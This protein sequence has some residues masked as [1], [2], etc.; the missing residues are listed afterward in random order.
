MT[1]E[2][3]YCFAGAQEAIYLLFQVLLR[4]GGHCLV[5]WPGYQSLYEVARG[6]GAE[7]SLVELHE[8][9][10]W[11]LSLERVR[12][13]WRR[14]TRLVAVNFPHNPTG[15]VLET[16]ELR[17]LAQLCEERGAWLFSDEV[18]YGA[19]WQDAPASQAVDLNCRAISLGVMSKSFGLAGLRVGWV[20]CR[21]PE[22]LRQV[23]ALKDYTSICNAA[24]SEAL[25]FIGLRA[26]Q[27]LWQRTRKLL[28]EHRAL[29][30]SL[31]DEFPEVLSWVPPQAGTMGFPRITTG[32]DVAAF[33]EDLRESRGV[34]ILPGSVY[35]HRGNH[36][37]VGLGRA[38][39][40][41]VLGRF[42]DFLIGRSST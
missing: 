28:G 9:E 18:Y 40:P 20:A 12:Q 10:G 8:S 39:F 14:D 35:G 5:T 33:A 27:N 13:Q 22:V 21:D 38:N 29:F 16:E 6:C 37:R 36:F 26:R 1:P 24:P 34:L 23:A 30:Q 17:E 2:D 42:R 11:K 15:S 31:V 32:E 19:N 3:I 41:E 4:E 25:A 7:V